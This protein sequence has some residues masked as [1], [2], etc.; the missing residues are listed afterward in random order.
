[1]KLYSFLLLLT[2]FSQISCVTGFRSK[3]LVYSTANTA[4]YELSR[5]QIPNKEKLEGNL[6]HPLKIAPEKLKDILG[7]LQFL[8]TTRI[9]SYQDYIYAEAELD[10]FCEDLAQ[11]LENLDD[12]NVSVVISQH[13]PTHSVISNAKR[14]SFIVFVNEE[15]LNFVFGEIQQDVSREKSYNFFDWTQIPPI[16]LVEVPDDNEIIL[17]KEVFNFKRQKGYQN[18]MWLV[19][20][21]KELGKYKKEQRFL[22]PGTNPN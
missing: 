2:L 13:D 15:G 9:N 21:L 17:K 14:T 10:K 8:K 19:F 18:R 11:T 7:N 6:L 1:M 4:F 12:K 20:S 16:G 3:K 5:K 22:E